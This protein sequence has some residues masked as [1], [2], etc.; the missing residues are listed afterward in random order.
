M[1]AFA[2]PA[3]TGNYIG[4][5]YVS[6]G[7]T[8]AGCHCYGLVRLLYREQLGI[9]L[10]EF[11]PLSADDV[12]AAAR[13]MRSGAV[14]PPWRYVEP[15]LRAFDGVVM[16][17]RS[18]QTRFRAVEG[19]AG[20]ML[21]HRTMLHVDDAAGAVKVPIDLPSIRDRIIGF[22]RHEALA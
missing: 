19:H 3:W 1:N 11:G 22:V 6:R 21:N 7:D 9:D 16:T 18:R 15:P 13:A 8:R 17:R 4:I 20:V 10:P 14:L 12:L 5:P 2:E